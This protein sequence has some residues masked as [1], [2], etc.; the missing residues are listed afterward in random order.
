VSLD[1]SEPLE[2]AVGFF[3]ARRA[4][5]TA[6]VH[7]DGVPELLRAERE[8]RLRRLLPA[9]S[10]ETVFF[11]SGSVSRGKAVPLSEDRLLFSALAYPERTGIAASDRVA[12]AVPVGQIFVTGNTAIDALLTICSR[13]EKT[14]IDPL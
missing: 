11:S 4:G 10:S 9:L 3:A 1:A 8:E 14:P 5:A 13:L 7:A 6:V 12:V 2:L